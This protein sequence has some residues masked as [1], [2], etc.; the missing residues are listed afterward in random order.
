MRVSAMLQANAAPEA[1]APM[2]S[3][4]TSSIVMGQCYMDLALRDRWGAV[5]F[6]FPLRGLFEHRLIHADPN[7]ANFSFL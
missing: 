7:R 4:S 1:P 6:D 3:T 2:I 5:Q